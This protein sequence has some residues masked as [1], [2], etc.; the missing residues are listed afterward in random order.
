MRAAALPEIPDLETVKERVEQIF[1]PGTTNRGH[2]TRE[3]ASK[4]I[5]VMLYVDAI[6]GHGWLRPN[7]VL[8]MTDAVAAQRGEQ[9]R[10][11]WLKASLGRAGAIPDRWYADTTREPIRDETLRYG[12]LPIGAVVER[13]GLN[14]TSSSP[15]W[16]L[17][18]DFAE[19]FLCSDEDFPEKVEAW[20][21]RRLSP[22]ALAR[23][24]AVQAGLA[25]GKK[26]EVLVTLPNRRTR[27]LAPGKSSVIS[28][29]VIEQFAPLYLEKPGVVW[30]SESSR[31]DEAADLRLA[32]LVRLDISES[33][34]LPDIILVDLGGESP[35]FVFVEVVSTDGPIN[36]QRKADLTALLEQGGHTVEDAA[37]VT[38]FLHRGE[39]AFRRLSSQIAWDSFVWFAAEPEK[40]ILF[41]DL[42]HETRNLFD[43]L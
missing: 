24:A 23:L 33:R 15:R 41:R 31:Q 42:Q 35:R 2:L 5:F 32:K 37:F 17:A 21:R 8:R 20:R 13:Q 27:I 7:Q 26:D 28:K 14:T 34:I 22:G 12:L 6:E 19:L 43:Y 18:A 39:A 29:A 30:L 1:P 25:E 36:D 4:T 9:E 38:A 10:R 11:D 40:M 3:M 16:A